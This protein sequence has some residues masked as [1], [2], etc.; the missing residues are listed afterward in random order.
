MNWRLFCNQLIISGYILKI[1]L[2]A[3][4]L[5]G[6]HGSAVQILEYSEYLSKEYQVSVA[7]I[8]A[9]SEFKTIFQKINVNI[10]EIKKDILPLEYDLVYSFHYPIFSYLVDKG[11]TTKKW[12]SGSLS[13]TTRLECFPSYWS[14]ANFLTVHSGRSIELHNIHY[15]IPQEMMKLFENPI[16]DEYVDFKH[17]TTGFP[18]LPGKIGIVSNHI[19]GELLDIK[20]YLPQNIKADFLGRYRKYARITPEI[21]SNYDLIIT[22]GKTVQYALGLGIPIYEYDIYGGCGYITSENYTP[23]F[24]QKITELKGTFQKLPVKR[25]FLNAWTLLKM[26]GTIWNL[27]LNL[28]RKIWNQL[29][30]FCLN[31]NG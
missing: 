29:H 15:G 19:P 11:L 1:L 10:Y 13:P 21:L 14:K 3:A 12:V 18:K 25:N 22:I 20:R 2:T 23:F 28:F 7:C 31:R 16:P 5:N 26:V 8:C 27:V 30:Q 17:H 24:R 9:T 6:W 4:Y